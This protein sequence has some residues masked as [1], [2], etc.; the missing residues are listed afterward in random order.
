M[1]AAF[2]VL[3]QAIPGG[4]GRRIAVL[5][6]MRELGKD[7]SARH[8]DLAG[9]LKRTEVDLVFTAGSDMAHLFEALEPS[10]RG[11]HEDSTDA[12]L[13]TVLAAIGSGDVVMIKGSHGSRTGLIVDALLAEAEKPG[14]MAPRVVNG[15]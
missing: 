11:A 5:G 2:E 4:G 12:L 8:A 15:H 6:D 7:S 1:N 14:D 10:M 13:P 3:G 9:S